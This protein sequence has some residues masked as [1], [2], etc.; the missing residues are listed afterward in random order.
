MNKSLNDHDLSEPVY[1]KV[2]TERKNLLGKDATH[3]VQLGLRCYNEDG[4]E[5]NNWLSLTF[6]G[7]DRGNY[8]TKDT[9]QQMHKESNF[10]LLYDGEEGFYIIQEGRKKTYDPNEKLFKFSTGKCSIYKRDKWFNIGKVLPMNKDE[11]PQLKKFQ[12]E[13]VSTTTIF[14]KDIPF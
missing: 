2:L 11:F 7:N 3:V 12:Q 13:E 9:V 5:Y 14:E 10:S 1:F 4:E 6:W 8:I